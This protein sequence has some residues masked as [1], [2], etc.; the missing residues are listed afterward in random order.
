MHSISSTPPAPGAIYSSWGQPSSR[1]L[2]SD[3]NDQSIASEA[4]SKTE[5]QGESCSRQETKALSLLRVMVIV[6]LVAACVLVSVSTFLCTRDKEEK[7]FESHCSEYA[8]LVLN[9]FQDRVGLVLASLDSLAADIS[10]AARTT[11]SE[12]PAVTV[13]DFEVRGTK[14]RNLANILSLIFLPVVTVD[15]RSAWEDHSV[16]DQSWLQDSLNFR[17][18]GTATGGDTDG[19]LE[20][21]PISPAIF[22]GYNY[23][24]EDFTSTT[25][26]TYLPLW[27]VSP[28]IPVPSI[29][30]CDMRSRDEFSGP[31]HALLKSKE[32]I[33]G[34]PVDLS[35]PSSSQDQSGEKI[36]FFSLLLHDPQ[37][38]LN[39]TLGPLSTFFYPIFD[40]YEEGSKLVGTLVVLQYWHEL[41]A[42]VLPTSADGIVVVLENTCNQTYTFQI[43][44]EQVLFLGDG[45]LHDVRFNLLEEEAN[46]VDLL[47]TRPSSSKLQSDAPLNQD[48]CGYKLRVYPS[49]QMHDEYMTNDATIFTA[50]MALVLISAIMGRLPSGTTPAKGHDTRRSVHHGSISAI[51]KGLS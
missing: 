1:S 8:S 34:K 26:G 27:Q 15:T 16:R 49:K 3:F 32:A 39:A 20:L 30:K 13:P 4:S 23:E 18:A 51:P 31:L 12:W 47:A 7:D 48:Y 11:G 33:I 37:V 35:A 10:S 24:V 6:V 40:G 5:Q 43:N 29:Y 22:S 36:Y 42:N 21:E 25:A 41:F 9:S 28:V 17:A 50:V 38:M 19:G 44:D 45:D 46:L 14:T 2:E